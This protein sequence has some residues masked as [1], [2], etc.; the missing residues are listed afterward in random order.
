M[1]FD[2][3]RTDYGRMSLREEQAPDEPFELFARWFDEAVADGGPDPNAMTLATVGPEG[4]SARIVL[5]RGIDA[6]AF[7]F[8]TNYES[9]KGRDLAEDPRAALCFFW[10]RLERQIRVEG[11]VERVEAAVSD[12]YFASRPRESRLGAWA[13]DQSSTVADR[14]ELERRFREAES[15][16][17]GAEPPRPPHWGGYRLTPSSLEFWQGGPGRM[18]DR[19]RYS[20]ATGDAAWTRARLCP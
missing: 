18:H 10:P 9:R 3:L 1:R 7:V 5:L 2:E 17:E 4:P 14:A 16:F 13:S 19:L 11:R 6:G 12:A 20:R 15:R 8:Y